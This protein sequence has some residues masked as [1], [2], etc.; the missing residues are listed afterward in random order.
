[1][2]SVKGGLA[3]PL[4]AREHQP[5]MGCQAV[6]EIGEDP[7]MVSTLDVKECIP[8]DDCIVGPFEDIS[9]DRRVD[10]GALGKSGAR[11]G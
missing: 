9:L 7:L 11:N 10:P 5:P 1:M 3:E 8:A 6:M 2:V 4:T